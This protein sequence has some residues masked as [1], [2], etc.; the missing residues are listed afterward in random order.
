MFRHILVTLDGSRRSEAIIPYAVD[1]GTRAGAALT[2][3]RVVTADAVQRVRAGERGAVGRPPGI[4]FLQATAQ[5]EAEAYLA[6]HAAHM[7]EAGVMVNAL[8]RTGDAATEI[9]AAADAVGADTIAMA[10]ASRRGID[11][12]MLG[13]VA[14]RVVHGTRTPVI[15][16]RVGT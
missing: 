5:A 9:V 16:L 7:R 4:D 10:T 1:L 15:L 3:V 11:R 2:L 8:V 14:E 6:G 12:L 13:S